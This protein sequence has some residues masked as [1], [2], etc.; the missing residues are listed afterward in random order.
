M[1]CVQLCSNIPV[2]KQHYLYVESLK[3]GMML[4]LFPEPTKDQLCSDELI[5][6]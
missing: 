2:V 4:L 5:N 1:I 6:T 3:F